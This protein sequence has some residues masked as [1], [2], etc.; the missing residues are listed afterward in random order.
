MKIYNV[1]INLFKRKDLS[2]IEMSR[3]TIKKM[4]YRL[5]GNDIYLKTY[6]NGRTMI[7]LSESGIKLKVYAGGYGESDF[8]PGPLLDQESLWKFI[9]EHEI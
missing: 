9:K 3:K 2:P 4:G 8:W 7:W 1:L 6:P 5:D